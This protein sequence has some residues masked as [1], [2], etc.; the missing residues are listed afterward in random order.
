MSAWAIVAGLELPSSAIPIRTPSF[1][2]VIAVL[3]QSTEENL[4]ISTSVKETV[5]SSGLN[6]MARL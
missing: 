2:I 6:E 1:D 4:A 5:W 3:S